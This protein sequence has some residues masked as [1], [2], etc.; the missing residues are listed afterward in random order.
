MNSAQFSVFLRKEHQH[1]QQNFQNNG[2]RM[3]V[4]HTFSIVLLFGIRSELTPFII[5]ET[6]FRAKRVDSFD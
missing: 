4:L 3:Y 5:F 6:D 2:K 1:Q